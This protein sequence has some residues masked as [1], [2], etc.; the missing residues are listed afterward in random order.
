MSS[1]Y[2]FH[3]VIATAHLGERAVV[4]GGVRQ[5]VLADDFEGHPLCGL[6]AVV[7]VAEQCQVAVGVHVDEAGGEDQALR[8]QLPARLGALTARR[9]GLLHDRDDPA[10][11]HDHI[12]AVRRAAAAV[13]D[14]RVPDDQLFHAHASSGVRYGLCAASRRTCL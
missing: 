11:V 8:V 13:D 3:P 9:R 1:P 5:P 10:A 12:G 4:D 2:P 14:V 7:R 6:G